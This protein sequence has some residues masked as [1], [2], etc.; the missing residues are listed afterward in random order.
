MKGRCACRCEN[1]RIIRFLVCRF[2]SDERVG[3][4]S[5]EDSEHRAKD[6]AT[7]GQDEA[8]NVHRDLELGSVFPKSQEADRFAD[9]RV[10]LSGDDILLLVSE[11]R[12]HA[13]RA[14][15]APSRLLVVVVVVG[16]LG[17]VG[18]ITGHESRHGVADLI[19]SCTLVVQAGI[20]VQHGKYRQLRRSW[21]C[22]RRLVDMTRHDFTTRR[23]LQ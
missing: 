23:R 15:S 14:D 7:K 16:R 12:G 4:R 8:D 1:D 18:R 13:V 22:F 20:V 19:L 5:H 3:Q 17:A 9:W 21:H 6:A 11:V 10:H 2:V